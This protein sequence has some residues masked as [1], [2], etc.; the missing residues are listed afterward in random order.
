MRNHAE[1]FF[2]WASVA[3]AAAWTLVGCL[4]FWMALAYT[5]AAHAQMVPA[6]A[7]KYRA[8]LVRAAHTQWG[9]DAPI[10]VFAAQVHQ[11]S[12]WRPEA[13]SRVGA[14]GMAQFMPATATWWCGKQ[15]I[16]AADCL[17]HN[18]AWAL[19]A[20]VGYNKWLY[21]RTPGEHTHYD[22]VWAMLRAYN[23]GLGHWQAERRLA[24]TDTRQAIDAACGSARRHIS[25]CRENLDYPFRIMVVL[26]PLYRSWGGPFLF[27]AKTVMNVSEGKA[28]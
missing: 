19:R 16:A 24:A 7:Q 23:G 13:V 9:L 12:A 14:Q 26:Q 8:Q 18:P 4:A 6:N 10:A 20:M 1:A 2:Q 3:L 25:H 21:E 17:P 11:E 28:N 15:R 5:H 27:P 22:R